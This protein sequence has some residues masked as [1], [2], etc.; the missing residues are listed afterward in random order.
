MSKNQAFIVFYLD[1]AL[2]LLYGLQMLVTALT[3]G[4]QPDYFGILTIGIGSATFFICINLLALLY[5]NRRKTVGWIL[6]VI[7]SLLRVVFFG[8][9]ISINYNLGTFSTIYLLQY[10]LSAVLPVAS[11]LFLFGARKAL[12]K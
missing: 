4:D 1:S 9:L 5:L 3:R 11:L 12:L 2:L 6:Y 10:I 7:S 8:M